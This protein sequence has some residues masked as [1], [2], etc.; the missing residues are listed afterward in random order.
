[1]KIGSRTSPALFAVVGLVAALVACGSDAGTNTSSDAAPT[2]P[3]A[4]ASVMLSV[5][6]KEFNF[7]PST[8]SAESGDV[9]V[10]FH[11]AGVMEH[12]FTIKGTTLTIAATAGQTATGSASLDPGTY[13]Y[14]CSIPGHD[15]A[16]MTGTL[17][18]T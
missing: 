8:L 6:G 3:E 15:N 5:S 1:M 13:T 11:N 14:L 9:R 18:V 10:S 12:D 4:P 2:V 16:G 7:E 17:T